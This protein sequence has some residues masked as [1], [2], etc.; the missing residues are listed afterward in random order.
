MFLLKIKL[1]R[2]TR[3]SASKLATRSSRRS[4]SLIG[5]EA[6]GLGKG[7]GAG[8]SPSP[9]PSSDSA[10]PPMPL[11]RGLPKRSPPLTTPFLTLQTPNTT[12]TEP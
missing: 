8:N 10:G 5:E 11:Q 12:I 4:V 9:A 2:L 1:S 7:R 3:R 6:S